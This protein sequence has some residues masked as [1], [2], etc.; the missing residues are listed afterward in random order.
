MWNDNLNKNIVGLNI[1]QI[2]GHLM[3]QYFKQYLA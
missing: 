1:I 2:Q 3:I